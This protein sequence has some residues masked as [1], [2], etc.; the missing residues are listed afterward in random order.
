ME[1][2]SRQ[3][4]FSD[5]NLD[6][7]EY[8]A[9]LMRKLNCLVALL[10][11]A[12]SRVQQT[13]AGPDP[14]VERLERIRS[15]LQSTLSVCVRARVALEER[16]GLPDE[17]PQ[18][19]GRITFDA[20]DEAGEGEA[21]S[22]SGLPPGAIVELSTAIEREKFERLGP[23]SRGEIDGADLDDLQRRLMGS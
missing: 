14:D 4:P 2:K 8:R 11:V 15:N 20:R 23:I 6:S 17:L 16:Q 3:D 18:V 10:E 1:D 13:L 9:R 5:E 22:D 21:L 7:P 12:I 19:L